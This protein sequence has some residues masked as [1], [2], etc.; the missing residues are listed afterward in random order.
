MD[1]LDAL[2]DAADYNTV[3]ERRTMARDGLVTTLSPC[4]TVPGMYPTFV[5]P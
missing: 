3:S 5:L 4:E 2:L 1:Q